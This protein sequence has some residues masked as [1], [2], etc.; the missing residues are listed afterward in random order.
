VL[1]VAAY[2]RTN[3]PPTPTPAWSSPWAHPSPGK[4]KRLRRA[5][6]G[7]DHLRPVPTW[8]L[9]R[10]CR[11]CRRGRPQ[12]RFRPPRRW[13]EL[14]LMSAQFRFA[15]SLDA[16]ALDSPREAS[17]MS[18]TRVR[19]G[20]LGPNIEGCQGWLLDM[21]YTPRPRSSSGLNFRARSP[22]AG[23]V[24]AGAGHR[25]PRTVH[26]V[27]SRPPPGGLFAS[28][29]NVGAQPCHPR[30]PDGHQAR[31][32]PPP[33]NTPTMRAYQSVHIQE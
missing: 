14:G 25:V 30:G 28:R 11:D 13:V 23:W 21:G 3:L 22:P 18:G 27:T 29:S 15:R 24:P 19:H 8:R 26:G 9:W 33:M 7:P 12:T 6:Q 32:G 20:L 17:A 2:L 5:P 10:D 31:V 16:G 4:S 1:L